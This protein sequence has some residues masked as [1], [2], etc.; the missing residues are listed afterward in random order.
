M[1]NFKFFGNS[2]FVLGC[3]FLL[4]LHVLGNPLATPTPGRLQNTVRHFQGRGI[5]EQLQLTETQRNLIRRNRAVFRIQSA[6]IDAKLKVNQV[7]LENELDRSNPDVGRLRL[8]CEKIG[9]LYGE[10]LKKKIVAKWE[11]EKKILTSQQLDRLKEIQS[12]E[13]S[14]KEKLGS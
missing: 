6:K 1:K 10:K 4:T 3:L 7:D 12:G 14:K 5:L 8:L 9:Q 11:L 13:T 2:F